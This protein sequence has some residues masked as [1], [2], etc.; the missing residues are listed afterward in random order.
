MLSSPTTEL[1]LDL[2]EN[3]PRFHHSGK[4]IHLWRKFL[5]SNIKTRTVDWSRV[6]LNMPYNISNNY[7]VEFIATLGIRGLGKEIIAI[8]DISLS[9]ECFGIGKY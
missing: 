2:I 6:S 5:E 7:R 1:S 3:D 9:K 8:K 4:H